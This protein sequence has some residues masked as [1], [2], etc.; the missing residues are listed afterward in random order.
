VRKWPS[1][2]IKPHLSLT[3]AMDG[4]HHFNVGT[5]TRTNS[6]PRVGKPSGLRLGQFGRTL[7]VERQVPQPSTVIRMTSFDQTTLRTPRL[8]LRPLR[9]SDAPALFVIFSDPRVTRYLSRPPWDTIDKA[10]DL[11]AKDR[12]SLAKGEYVRFGIERI[13]GQE[14]IGECSLFNLI[15]RCRRAEVGYVLAS[16][17]WGHGYMGEAL[18]S[19]LQFGFSQL[20]LNRV[21]ADIDPRNEPSARS[22]QR[23]GF[24]KEGHLRERWIVGN[25]VSDTDLYGLLLSDWQSGKHHESKAET[26]PVAQPAP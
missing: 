4:E 8:L 13:H 12:Q 23:L 15:E 16:G 26:E 2:D 7:N 9:E 24:K 21:E 3:R 20:V 14:L 5:R 19:L 22:L 6:K 25:E 17:A 1:F 10:F 18:I 11:I